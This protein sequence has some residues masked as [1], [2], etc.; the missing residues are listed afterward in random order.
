MKRNYLS[1]QPGRITGSG[2]LSLH[3]DIARAFFQQLGYPINLFSLSNDATAILPRLCYC[4]SND[5]LIGLAIEDD[6]LP[7]LKIQAGTK[8]AQMLEYAQTYGLATQAELFLLNPLI[9]GFPSFVLVA[10]AQKSGPNAENVSRR[11][12]IVAREMA[13]RGMYIVSYQSD[14]ASAQL[15]AMQTRRKVF[16]TKLL[17]L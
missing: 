4:P 14:G 3:L 11:W 16:S 8:F 10:F 17:L 5:A 7:I 15:K 2:I 13:K 6:S 12:S 9:P 1:Y